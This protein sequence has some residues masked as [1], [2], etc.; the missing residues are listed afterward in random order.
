MLH[1]L[2]SDIGYAFRILAR[3]RA[4]AIIA[5]TSLAIGIG[6]NTAMFSAVDAALFRPLPVRE[7]DRLADVYT[8]GGDG[9]RYATSSYPDFLDFRRQQTV[10]ED[11]LG[12]SPALAAVKV[13]DRSRMAIGEVVTGNYFQLLGVNAVAGRTLLPED[14]KPGAARAVAISH[15][16]WRTAYGSN[17]AVLG[18]TIAIHGQPYTVVGVVA[19]G[20][21]GLFPMLQPEMWIPAAWV[22]EVE[23]AGIQHSVPSPGDTRLERR[24]QRWLFI[25]GRLARGET[26]ER[27]AANLE[28][29]M[30]QLAAAHPTTN[31]N[32]PVSVVSGVRMHPDA[33]R[34]L[35]PIASGLMI[36]IGLV[37]VIACANVAN[38]LLARA[39]G[40]QREIG[41]RIAIGASRGRLI[42]Q[43]LTESVVLAA[44]GGVAGIGLAALL[45]RLIETM[46]LP[47]PVAL[48]LGLRID[49]RVLAFTAV[50]A[51]IAGVLAGLA[52]AL[53]GTRGSVVSDLK[54][55]IASTSAAG[56][57]WTLRDALV[58][59]QTAVTLVLLVAAALLTRSLMHAHTIDLGFRTE[60]LIAVASDLSLIGY[61]AAGGRRLYE[62]AFER[63]AALPGVTSAAR[64]VRQP[65]AINYNRNNVFF[66]DRQAA[67][68]EGVSIA[69]TWVDDRY[70]STLGVRLLR[71]RNFSAADTLSSPRV[72]VVTEAFTRRYWA[73]QD[74]IGRRFRLR[75]ADG[76]EYQVVGVVS[77]YKVETVGEAPAPY[78]HYS[79][80]Q[81]EFSNEVVLVRTTLD[82]DQAIAAVRREL[83][84]LEP[85]IVFFESQTMRAQVDATLLPT[86]LIAQSIG[87]VGLVGTALAAIGLYGAIA[88]SVAR[89]TREI[90]IRV[91]IGATPG[92]VLRLIMRHGL[93]VAAAGAVVGGALAWFAARAIA[94]GLYGAGA[95][96]PVAWAAAV[97]VLLGASAL[98]NYIP[99]RRAA[100]LDPSTAL[101]LE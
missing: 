27:A 73:G 8:R 74:P 60:G 72:A 97:G 5:V 39:S 40:R 9:D 68:E 11:M 65:L 57:R 76:P 19:E 55:D 96:D 95:A 71:G 44:L 89:R 94:A 43:L 88:Y 24:G 34:V 92:S 64:A 35:R 20:F 78:I 25:K 16:L 98:A 56:R 6:F 10:F 4:F 7:A 63:I 93:A 70:F 46:P 85:S 30:R 28:V 48:D 51:A 67:G 53:R 33:D 18:T 42:R 61:D 58:G 12:Y 99:A 47:I 45:L 81:R 2:T 90:G 36:G 3:N 100:R 87:L 91:A 32:R 83:L 101:R 23:P 59:V 31:A 29:I 1:A 14:D 38:M 75:G 50:V 80:A 84:A 37:L 13:G 49:G 21:S 41:V 22:E 26:V 15:T 66:P 69:A 62:R 54:G 82:P 86:R 52:P 17:S 77:D 79:L